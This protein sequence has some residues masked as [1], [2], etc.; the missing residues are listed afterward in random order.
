MKFFQPSHDINMKLS[1]NFSAEIGM[2]L[3]FLFIFSP[4]LNI[5]NTMPELKSKVNIILMGLMYGQSPLFFFF[6][7]GRAFDIIL[8]E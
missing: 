8:V 3:T 5:P 4:I 6:S 7:A 2:C 1:F